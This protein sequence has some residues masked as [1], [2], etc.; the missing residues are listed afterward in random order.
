[1]GGDYLA[2]V[3][4]FAAGPRAFQCPSELNDVFRL[5]A[6]ANRCGPQ[7]LDNPQR[8]DNVVGRGQFAE[9]DNAIL[10]EARSLKPA[11]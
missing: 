2:R 7:L 9:L 6:I 11:M 3:L 4:T 5:C 8:F 10:D 1:M